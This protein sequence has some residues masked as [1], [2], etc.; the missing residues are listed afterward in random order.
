MTDFRA[1]LVNALFC[2]EEW[3][4]Q[5]DGSSVRNLIR[6][7]LGDRDVELIQA[8]KLVSARWGD[9]KGQQIDTTELVIRDL[10]AGEVQA[11][12]ELSQGVA[13]LLSVVTCSEVRVRAYEHAD[14]VPSASWWAV[15]G[16]AW[17]FSPTIETV[18]GSAV[19][20]FLESTWRA[21][22]ELREPRKLDVAF[23]YF[24][25][26]QKPGYPIELKLVTA[27][28][29]LE[30]LRH[31]FAK[32]EGYPWIKRRFREKGVTE[33]NAGAE[34]GFKE[35]LMRMFQA[36]G[37]K[38]DLELIVSLRNELIHEGVSPLST[39][40]HFEAHRACQDLIREY[41]LR[42]LGYRGPYFPF[43]SP[44]VP[45]PYPGAPRPSNGGT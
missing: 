19:R 4:P 42:L 9:Y 18:D 7:R 21:Y 34:V 33:A 12:R 23:E 43:S 27:F 31:T 38:P 25:L 16:S 17:H 39:E 36:V 32:Q 2:G 41:L 22:L 1:I 40:E 6:L 26:S 5:A 11:A 37:M 24:V 35:M 30:N 45:V 3:S 8:T 15:V 14:A 29:L 13:S 10:P 28:V 44:N 20:E